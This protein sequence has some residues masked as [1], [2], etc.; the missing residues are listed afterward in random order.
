MVVT[1]LNTVKG[2]DKIAV[3]KALGTK[4]TNNRKTNAN[5]DCN[6]FTIGTKVLTENGEKSIEE[7]E[8]GDKVLSRDEKTGEQSYKEVEWLFEKEVDEIYEIHVS[9]EIIKTTDEHPFWV[10]EENG[11]VMAQDLLVGDHFVDVNGNL[12]E[13]ERIVKKKEI[14]RVYNFKVS[15]NHNYYVSN[16]GIWTHNSCE[17]LPHGQLS[18]FK[19]GNKVYSDGQS[20]HLNQDK[21]YNSVIPYKDGLAI[22]LR[23]HAKKDGTQHNKAHKVLEDFWDDYRPGGNLENQLPSNGKYGKVMYKSLRR[24]GVDEKDARKAYELAREQRIGY[25]LFDHMPVPNIPGSM[26]LK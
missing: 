9:G 1:N 16:L 17:I 13:I 21:A 14:S 15:D 18:P 7:V 8:I 22:E 23:G 11:W 12:L 25:N 26:N 20:H 5:K 4:K 10:V 19:N 2:Y 3:N 24:A 6:C